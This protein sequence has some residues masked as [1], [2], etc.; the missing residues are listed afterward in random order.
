MHL[1]QDIFA[2]VGDDK[3]LMMWDIRERP[4]VPQQV[5]MIVPPYTVN[6]GVVLNSST[7]LNSFHSVERAR[8]RERFR[9]LLTFQPK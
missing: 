8:T 1:L 9:E 4:T 2:S 3:K 6:R 5:P 7:E